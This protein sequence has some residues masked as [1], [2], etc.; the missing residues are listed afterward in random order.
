MHILKRIFFLRCNKKIILIYLLKIGTFKN[1][2]CR[3]KMVISKTMR[4]YVKL[5]FYCNSKINAPHNEHAPCIG[6]YSI[7]VTMHY[8]SVGIFNIKLTAGYYLIN[9][10]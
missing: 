9:Q 10:N 5:I 4:K 3:P 8:R 2:D 7:Q 1:Q 6:Y